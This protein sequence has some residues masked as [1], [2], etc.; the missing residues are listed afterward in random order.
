[1]TGEDSVYFINYPLTISCTSV[2][3]VLQ[4]H[5]WEAFFC[6]RKRRNIC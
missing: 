1:V 3:N 2:G 4:R 6:L 5:G